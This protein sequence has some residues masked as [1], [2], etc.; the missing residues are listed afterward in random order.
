[1]ESL[2]DILREAF[3]NTR[4]RATTAE[5]HLRVPGIIANLWLGL[6]LG[7][8][9]AE[10]V[11]A[12]AC[13]EVGELRSRCWRALLD[14]GARQA[15]TVEQERPTRRF[16]S[17]LATLLAQGRCVLLEND[18]KPNLQSASVSVVGWQDEDYIYLLAEASF[19]CVSRFCRDSGELFPVRS[20]RLSRDF[21]REG[22]SECS[23]GR[24]SA[25]ARLGGQQRRVLKLRRDRAEN[26]L[27]EPLPGSAFSGTVETS[28]TASE[29]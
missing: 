10:E 11:G 1:M 23:T 26:L 8:R 25:T 29:E 21:N 13:E 28:G 9:Y 6:D 19:N 7:M 4:L 16:L 15:M 14:V 3:D 18:S 17:V 20:E 2:P 5:A 22:V 24:N 12:T 27:G